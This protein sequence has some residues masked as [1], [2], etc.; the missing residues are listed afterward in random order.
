MATGWPNEC[1]REFTQHDRLVMHLESAP[2]PLRTRDI[3]WTR[4]DLPRGSARPAL[5]LPILVRR[6]LAAIALYG[7][8]KSGADL[9]PDEI[10]A[11][12]A[13]AVAAGAAYDHLEADALRKQVEK[14]QLELTRA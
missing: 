9:D 2:V 6:R 1:A 13:L 3:H 14:L 8:P 5:A 11:I 10:R 4:S 12:S 7:E